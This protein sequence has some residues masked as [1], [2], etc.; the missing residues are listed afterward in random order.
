MNA[1]GGTLN[2]NLFKYF[3]QLADGSS[4]ITVWLYLLISLNIEPW[5]YYSSVWMMSVKDYVPF[6]FT[7]VWSFNCIAFL[8]TSSRALSHSNKMTS[9]TTPLDQPSI[10]TD[11]DDD[12]G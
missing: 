4:D 3:A 5:S 6:F 10:R 9:H 8:Y 2:S 7:H 11:E 1:G 12:E